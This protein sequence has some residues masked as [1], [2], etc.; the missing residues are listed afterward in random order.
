MTNICDSC[1][2]EIKDKHYDYCEKTQK[3]IRTCG[4]CHD[5]MILIK[6]ENEIRR[7]KLS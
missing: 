3:V 7:N 4:K 2:G 5:R 6:A 1:G